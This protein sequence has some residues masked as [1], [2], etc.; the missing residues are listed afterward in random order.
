MSFFSQTGIESAARNADTLLRYAFKHARNR[1]TVTIS[2]KHS[3]NASAAP[4]LSAVN[5]HGRISWGRAVSAEFA[6]FFCNG[7]ETFQHNQPLHFVTL[8]DIDCV[9]TVSADDFSLPAI[10]GRLRRGLVGLSY[11]AVIEP[12]FYV[13]WAAGI[14]YKDQ[15]RLSWHLHAIVWG[16]SSADLT[17]RI[18]LLNR[19]GQVRRVCT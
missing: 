14:A 2:D 5:S 17:E 19:S 4:L 8:I 18:K 13:N 12:A 15:R 1:D 11:V 10:I 9:K 16:I 6:K 7:S 3:L